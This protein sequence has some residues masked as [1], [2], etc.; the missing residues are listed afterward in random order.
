MKKL[1]PIYIFLLSACVKMV[2]NK[3]A[4]SNLS[5]IPKLE[6]PTSVIDIPVSIDFA[7]TNLTRMIPTHIVSPNWDHYTITKLRRPEDPEHFDYR[8]DIQHTS[9]TYYFQGNSIFLNSSFHLNTC[10]GNGCLLYIPLH[11]CL[12]GVNFNCSNGSLTASVSSTLNVT[13]NFAF[14]SATTIQNITTK[15]CSGTVAWGLHLPNDVF[16]PIIQGRLGPMLT[17]AI[18]AGISAYS[19]RQKANDLWNSLSQSIKISDGVTLNLNPVKFR[20]SQ[21]NGAGTVVNFSIG[22][23]AIPEVIYGKPSETPPVKKMPVLEISNPGNSF[24]LLLNLS[25]NLEDLSAVAENALK[26]KT[27]T[28]DNNS[29]LEITKCSIYGQN[30]NKLIFRLRGKGKIK[31]LKTRKAVIYLIGTPVLNGQTQDLALMNI[32]YDIQTSNFFLHIGLDLKRAAIKDSIQRI[33]K[34]NLANSFLEVKGKIE[35]QLNRDFNMGRLVTNINSISGT[36]IHADSHKLTLDVLC[37]GK[38]QIQLFKNLLN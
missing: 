11:I 17:S 14:S 15:G 13:P 27:L 38:M 5:A 30:D 3:P 10:E 9:T 16:A 1:L 19:F 32:D 25:S 8:F 4:L 34:N 26:G 24:N 21:M 23:D 22:L 36:S 37:N 12:A 2:P 29:Y 35:D 7:T 33:M 6:R 28:L 18:D 20:A 31:G